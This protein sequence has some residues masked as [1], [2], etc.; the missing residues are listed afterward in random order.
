[1]NLEKQK[2]VTISDQQEETT[3]SVKPVEQSSQ[4]ANPANQ[5]IEDIAGQLLEQSMST[6]GQPIAEIT[7]AE[8]IHN[9]SAQLFDDFGSSDDN[10]LNERTDADKLIN[11]LIQNF[12]EET[13]FQ[14]DKAL[15]DIMN[16][17][18]AMGNNLF[19][20]YMKFSHSFSFV[21]HRYMW[22]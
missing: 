4:S 20:L 11:D 18:F 17:A 19:R 5:Q 12:T 3:I 8:Y 22:L 1:M 15:T 21:F 2:E 13:P 10:T 7:A 6:E 16:E 9:F 14:Q